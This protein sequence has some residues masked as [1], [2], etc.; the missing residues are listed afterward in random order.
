MEGFRGKV[1]LFVGD[2]L[3]IT[4]VVPGGSKSAI[5]ASSIYCSELMEEARYYQFTKILRLQNADA[6]P[7]QATYARLLQGI[8]KNAFVEASLPPFYVACDAQQVDGILRL[9]IPNLLPLFSPGDCLNF[10]YPM[11]FNTNIMHKSCILAATNAQVEYWNSEVQRLNTNETWTLL[12]RDNFEECDDPHGFLKAMVT[13]Q[14]MNECEDPGSA[15]PHK[16]LLKLHDICILM[17]AVSKSDKLATNTRVRVIGLSHNIVRVTTLDAVGARIACLP[18]FVFSIKVTYGRSFHI[19]RRQFPLRLAYS[20][21]MNRS[22]GQTLDRVVVDLTRHCFMHGHLNVAL[23]RIREA[24][25]IAVHISGNDYDSDNKMVITTNVVY[26]E[27]VSA[28][29]ASNS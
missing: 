19:T 5:C 27:I 11:G 18:R 13:E 3:Q 12:S 9:Y 26:P 22:Q 14:V 17:R 29:Y 7:N 4:P 25:N 6:D 23:S 2:G 20:L 8:S 16:L 21:T 28:L 10:C 24:S 15:P 1:L